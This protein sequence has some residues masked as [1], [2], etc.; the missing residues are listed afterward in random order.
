MH[1]NVSLY[2]I[3]C[4]SK[5]WGILILYKVS[6]GHLDQLEKAWLWTFPFLYFDL[7]SVINYTHHSVEDIIY[8]MTN[9]DTCSCILGSWGD[10][11]WS[12]IT[13]RPLQGSSWIR[14]L[15]KN[16]FCQAKYGD[17]LWVQGEVLQTF[18]ILHLTKDQRFR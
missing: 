5:W 1:P 13:S 17:I 10:M 14:N 12:P 3:I 6:D 7:I 9:R 18:C 11:V 15:G 8:I 4:K 2:S 16:N